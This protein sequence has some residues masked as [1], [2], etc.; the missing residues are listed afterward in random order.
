MGR[1]GW[2]WLLVVAYAQPEELAQ[3]NAHPLDDTDERIT[4]AMEQAKRQY[5]VDPG[6]DWLSGSTHLTTRLSAL[7]FLRM[8]GT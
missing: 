4:Y 3:N 6:M 2:E 1:V 8:N 5:R 7:N